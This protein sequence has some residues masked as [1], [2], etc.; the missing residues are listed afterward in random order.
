MVAKADDWRR[1]G[2]E[3]YLRGVRLTWKRYQALR[4]DWEH[5]HCAFCFQKFLDARYSGW[6]RR[7]LEANPDRNDAAGYTTVGDDGQEAG[8]AW[9]CKQCFADFAEEFGW[10]VVDTDPEAWPYAV[11]EPNQRPTASDV[12]SDPGG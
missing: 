6:A 11:P 12:T 1:M 7:E 8:S 2:Q 9:I 10:V 4:A 5:E 3:R